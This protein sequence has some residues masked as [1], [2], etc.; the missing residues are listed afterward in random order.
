MNKEQVERIQAMERALN[1]ASG[2]VEALRTALEGYE[3]VRPQLE[4]LTAYY[5]SRQ[6]MKDYED[7]QAGRLPEGLRRGV[8]SEDA[9]YDLLTDV[10]EMEKAMAALIGRS[11]QA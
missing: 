2:A 5:E 11:E 9:V 10:A 6:W 3:R 4:K 7:D 1:E 8:L